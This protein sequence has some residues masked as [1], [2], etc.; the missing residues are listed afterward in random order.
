MKVGLGPDKECS[1]FRIKS[2]MTRYFFKF[3]VYFSTYMN[4][5][6]KMQ[7]MCP[8]EFLDTIRDAIAEGGGGIIGKYTH[9]VFVTKGTGYF[10]PMEGSSPSIGSRGTLEKVDEVKIEFL[11]EKEAV[12]TVVE[13]IK[14]VHPYEEIPIDMIPLLDKEDFS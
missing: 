12:H 8:D 14:S 9:C 10:M 6:V 13:K 4:N 7:V 11:C 3:I 5:Y 2:G 1:R